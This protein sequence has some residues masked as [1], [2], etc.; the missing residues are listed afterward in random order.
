V[1]KG[2]L[3]LLLCWWISGAF[4]PVSD[5]SGMID[6]VEAGALNLEKLEAMTC[7]AVGLDNSNPR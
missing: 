6:S 1:K 7:D 4:I 5:R 2:V 3:W